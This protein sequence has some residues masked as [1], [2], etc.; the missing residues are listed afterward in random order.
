M[1]FSPSPPRPYLSLT[2]ELHS[3]P[4]FSISPSIL[5]PTTLGN[6]SSASTEYCRLL[7]SRLCSRATE[8]SRV[9]CEMSMLNRK[10][11]RDGTIWSHAL[12][13]WQWCCFSEHVLHSGREH[14]LPAQSTSNISREDHG[15][16]IG[17]HFGFKMVARSLLWHESL[18]VN[19]TLKMTQIVN[20]FSH[21]KNILQK[22]SM[23]TMT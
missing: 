15:T 2:E 13:T 19:Q 16:S 12:D 6:R 1:F 7:P 18:R 14:G 20:I 23:H 17:S 4:L 22:I 21:R 11:V 9:M 8:Y 5:V 3:G 10:L